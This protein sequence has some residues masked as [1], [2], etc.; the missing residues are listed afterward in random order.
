M[1]RTCFFMICRRSPRSKQK[2]VGIPKR[3]AHLFIASGCA[4]FSSTAGSCLR[5]G[6]QLACLHSVSVPKE[7][8]RHNV[9]P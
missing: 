6:T 3:D 9:S 4:Y 1:R 8:Q 7:S 2:Q 5:L